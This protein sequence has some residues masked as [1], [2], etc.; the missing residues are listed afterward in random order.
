MIPRTSD[1][2]QILITA[3]KIACNDDKEKVQEMLRL[4]RERLRRKGIIK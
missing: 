2:E 3:L 4:S 1:K